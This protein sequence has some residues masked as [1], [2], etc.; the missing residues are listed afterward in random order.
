MKNESHIATNTRTYKN[1][2]TKCK[3]FLKKK[4]SNIELFYIRV[5]VGMRFGKFS[6]ENKF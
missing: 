3:K 4:V 5:M 2:H 6:Q 1:Y